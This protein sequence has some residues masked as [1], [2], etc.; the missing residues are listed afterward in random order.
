MTI[1]S[2]T[3][4]T[5]PFIGNG[6]ASTFAFP[7]KVFTA[8]DLFVQRVTTADGTI[9]TLFLTTD[10][11]ASLN[12][13]QNTNPGGSITLVAGAL[14]S[15]YTLTITSDIDN[16]QPTDL[17]NQGGFYPEVIT[18]SL[19][20]ATI[21]IQQVADTANN[22]I[23]APISD[24]ALDMTLPAKDLR[25]GKFLTFSAAGLPIV[26]DGTVTPDISSGGNVT[27]TAND[28]GANV[29]RDVIFV[30]NTTERMRLLG[31]TGRLGIGTPSPTAALHL[32][33]GSDG[34]LFS[35]DPGDDGTTNSAFFVNPTNSGTVRVVG[36]SGLDFRTGAIGGAT[37]SAMEIGS[38]QTIGINT[39][40]PT[41]RIFHVTGTTAQF[42]QEISN[43]ASADPAGLFIRYTNAAPNLTDTNFFIRCDDTAATR[44][45][46]DSAGNAENVNGVYG[47]ISDERLKEQITDA[48][49]Q[50]S[51]I[52]AIRIVNY[53]LKSDVAQFGEGATRMLGVLA[54]ELEV[55]AP[56][57]VITS[58]DL[59][60]DNNPLGTTTKTV[61]QSILYMKA[62]KA[63]QEAMSRIESLEARV[64]ALEA[65][66]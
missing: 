19:D 58:A 39:T 7:F 51:D 5:P 31:A 53:K 29:D 35:R 3:R 34:A 36:Q 27:I 4:V 13:N 43:S 61:K 46:V 32:T 38:A 6:T 37:A 11:T 64:A 8:A 22:A 15:G 45:R 42:V 12:G 14:A 56:G 65:G 16:L 20:R 30:D 47:T 59:D 62:V 18:D 60:A 48:S 41:N 1:S 25:N 66:A 9:T 52:K 17:T 10:Y 28:A 49:S 24:G 63:L 44:F 55:V 40:P 33:T 2:T 23:H 54:Q 57:L 21:Q 26:S 50:W